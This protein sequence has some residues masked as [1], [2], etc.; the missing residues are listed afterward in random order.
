MCV[1][2]DAKSAWRADLGR[3]ASIAALRDRWRMM[4]DGDGNT[5]RLEIPR[6]AVSRL[7]ARPPREAH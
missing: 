1:V 6:R 2:T 7:V 3:E 5:L 4:R